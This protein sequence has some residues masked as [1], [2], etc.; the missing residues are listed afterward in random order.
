MAHIS[1]VGMEFGNDDIIRLNLPRVMGRAQIGK[2]SCIEACVVDKAF[3]YMMV[4][5]DEFVIF[6][7]GDITGKKKKLPDKIK[8]EHVVDIIK[9]GET[10]DLFEEE[11]LNARST[12]FYV[13]YHPV[14]GNS[15]RKEKDEGK[16]PA[17]YS[18]EQ[19]EIYTYAPESLV[20]FYI[21]REWNHAMEVPLVLCALS[22][23]A[24]HSPA[25]CQQSG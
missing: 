19:F 14:P 22:A 20:Y 12:H 16:R 3:L 2:V 13:T 1:S 18:V 8:F 11:A 21:V 23:Y 5:G 15:S 17:E 24:C 25:V 9:D 4:V 6:D 10:V 7:R